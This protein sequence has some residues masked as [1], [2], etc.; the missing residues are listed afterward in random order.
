[1]KRIFSLFLALAA[2]QIAHAAP[3]TKASKAAPTVQ[4][5]AAAIELMDKAIA[6]YKTDSG[7]RMKIESSMNTGKIA[8]ERTGTLQWK[9]P[10]LMRVE[11]GED[12]SSSL[13]LSD[14]KALFISSDP[15][16]FVRFP[17]ESAPADF[18]ANMSAM[19][20]YGAGL[21]QM[22]VPLLTGKNPL[23]QMTSAAA[24]F[25]SGSYRAERLPL[26]LINGVGSDGLRFTTRLLLNGQLVMMEAT[27]WFDA[28]THLLRRVQTII[29]LPTVRM[30]GAD[31]ITETDLSPTFAPETFVWSPPP[32]A[33]EQ[34]MGKRGAT[35]AYFDPK[36]KVGS[37]PY[38]LSGA[39]LTKY[40]GKV[41]LLDFWATWCGPCVAELPSVL[42]NYKKY[43]A[44]GFDV[45]GIS[46]D[47][48]KK[49]L[50]DF[51][52]AHKLPWPQ[53]FDGKAWK[54]ENA[55]RYGVQAIPFTLLIGRDGKIVAVNPRGAALEREIQKA[56]K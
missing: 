17:L 22:L 42:S 49:A 51:V 4:V 41:L 16:N 54:G 50:N 24:S 8:Q 46:L 31:N 29:Q 14:G 39:D 36:L 3:T 1:M 7:L 19:V 18:V 43:K 9:A 52:K 11:R 53:L 28:K 5:D 21:G 25:K 33:T 2:P 45:L 47:N 48:D 10:N 15:Q 32:G 38:P 26:T 13:S 20:G 56:L 27:G 40:R 12:K 6:A 34:D 35:P 30:V 23:P 44:R 55:T 37:A